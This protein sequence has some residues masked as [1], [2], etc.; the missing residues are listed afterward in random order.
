MD[1]RGSGQLGDAHDRVLDVAGGDH[2]QVGEFVHDHQ[3]VRVGL[4][5]SLAAGRGGELAGAYRCV[6]VVDVA[7]AGGG[8][9]VVAT[10][11]L[12]TTHWRASA[13]FLGLV[14]MG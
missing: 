13:A 5:R 1:A 3:Q 9:V 7:V 14:M 6:E 4:V 12:P 11:H 2:H 10:V 8:Q